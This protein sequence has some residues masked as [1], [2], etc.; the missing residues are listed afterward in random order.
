MLRRLASGPLS[1]GDI[2]APFPMSLPAASKHIR[3]L[4]SAGVL[5]RTVKGR[6]HVLTFEGG[7]LAAAQ[8][9]L[10]FYQGFWLQQLDALGAMLTAEGAI[11]EE[12]EHAR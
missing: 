7:P 4:E 1:V 6:T 3:V 12:D 5:R 10:E 11:Q 8:G 2:A 9:W